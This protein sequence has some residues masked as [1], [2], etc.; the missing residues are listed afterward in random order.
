MHLKMS[1]LQWEDALYLDWTHSLEG[2]SKLFKLVLFFKSFYLV[3]LE[4]DFS[5]KRKYPKLILQLVVLHC[6]HKDAAYIEE[7]EIEQLPLGPTPRAA[8]RD[9]E[10]ILEKLCFMMERGCTAHW[11]LCQ[12]ISEASV[13]TRASWAAV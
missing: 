13:C 11:V 5:H 2:N 9:D 8:W 7:R 10:M 1:A 6:P 12:Q 4:K 3:V